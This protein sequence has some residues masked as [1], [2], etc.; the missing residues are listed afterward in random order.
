[1]NKIKTYDKLEVVGAAI[2]GGTVRIFQK[3][4]YGGNL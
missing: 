1:L 4:F 2:Y 3:I